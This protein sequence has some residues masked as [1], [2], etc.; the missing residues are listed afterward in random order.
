MSDNPFVGLAKF[1]EKNKL[2]FF[3]R[4]KDVENSIRIIQE[5]KL[6][7]LSG[8]T[9]CG[10]SS[11][12]N[13]GL[14]PRLKN[15]FP[16]RFGN[17]WAICKFR[18]S[19]SLLTNFCNAL[20][21][22]ELNHNNKPNPS[23]FNRY[24]KLMDE[25]AIGLKKIY[26]ESSIKSNKNLLIIIDQIEDLFN[27]EDEIDNK[28]DYKEFIFNTISRASQFEDTP[29][30]FCISIQEKFSK[31]LTNYNSIQEIISG[32]EYKIGKPN[33]NIIKTTVEKIFNKE[34]IFFSQGFYKKVLTDFGENNVSLTDLQWF[35]H[36]LYDSSPKNQTIDVDVFEEIGTVKNCLSKSY[37]SFNESL[38]D[39]EKLLFKNMYKLLMNVQDKT[40][41]KNYKKVKEIC[42]YCDV[43]IEILQKF[44]KKLNSVFKL[45][46]EVLSVTISATG[47]LRTHIEY[48]DY[49][50]INYESSEKY[51]WEKIIKWKE[52]EEKYLNELLNLNQIYKNSFE[53]NSFIPENVINEYS[54]KNR[55]TV[56][57]HFNYKS[58]PYNYGIDFKELDSYFIRCAEHYK[59]INREK[60]EKEDNR[61]RRKR[62]NNLS[63]VSVLIF[64]VLI[65]F[66][67]SYYTYGLK[68]VADEEKRI[69]IQAENE[70]KQAR[71]ELEKEKAVADSLKNEALALSEDLKDKSKLLE[72]KSTRLENQTKE[73][74]KANEEVYDLV[75]K[76]EKDRDSINTLKDLALETS[77]T[78]KNLAKESLIESSFGP[79]HLKLKNS[80]ELV[81]NQKL[82]ETF[83]RQTINDGLVLV[84]SF[85]RVSKKI[86]GG[87]GRETEDKY[88]FLHEALILLE[89]KKE[90]SETSMSLFR[91]KNRE[92][93]RSIDVFN[94]K[95]VFGGDNGIVYY[96]DNNFDLKAFNLKNK[97]FNLRSD[98]ISALRKTGPEIVLAGTVNGNVFKI[99]LVEEKVTRIHKSNYQIDK[100]HTD[101][102]KNIYISTSESFEVFNSEFEL[103]FSEYLTV[104]YT[105]QDFL[106]EIYIS[107]KNKIFKF[108]NNNLESIKIDINSKEI[109]NTFDMVYSLKDDQYI[110]LIGSESGKLIVQNSKTKNNF[111][112]AGE[113][114]IHSDMI[115]DSYLD[116]NNRILYTSSLDNQLIK[117]RLDSYEAV[118]ME[119]ENSNLT[120]RFLSQIILDGN[121]KPVRKINK[122]ID[123]VGKERIITV[124]DNGNVLSWYADF[125][126][127]INKV[128][129]LA[130]FK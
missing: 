100:I 84:D 116:Y 102:D 58:W 91:N 3:Q 9:G 95:I 94:N 89:G 115:T 118:G 44:L 43:E 113:R 4:E 57:S 123:P 33:S 14:I 73:L 35:F 21:N 67:V 60:K 42:E 5:K 28:I 117:F 65:G 130:S 59:K 34:K 11:L 53:N 125:K 29:I 108:N 86:Y 24:L 66:S 70:A 17:E 51:I 46:F 74:T 72:D 12:I 64:L 10:K 55:R 107:S 63:L 128:K 83:L 96:Q 8:P 111:K 77:L 39:N 52:D 97:A 68:E 19:L 109:I 62:I 104:S 20:S 22:G 75:S 69:A 41:L 93:I 82:D 25:G 126:D 40:R 49:I 80:L 105:H 1:E 56:F 78:N 38:T 110:L 127:L 26:Q 16:G 31:N 121:K 7:V 61:K 87:D 13:A 129:E 76:I 85:N 47:I 15:G 30:Y 106:D 92:E 114:I 90:Y 99:N 98:K 119:N 71:V 79:L 37:E 32:S 2:F 101:L 18:P 88:L 36:K 81:Q 124:D 112:L 54:D 48:S 122:Y 27:F 6:L 50:L 120:S 103:V 23:D 45:K